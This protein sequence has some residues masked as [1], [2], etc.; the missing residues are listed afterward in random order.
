MRLGETR[1]EIVGLV[2]IS[3]LATVSF[4]WF[5]GQPFLIGNDT[6]LPLNLRTIDSYFY[7]LPTNLAYAKLDVSKFTFLLPLGLLLKLYSLSGLP[8]SAALYERAW[9]YVALAFCGVSVFVLLTALDKKMSLI[10]KLFA[11]AVFMFNFFHVWYWVDVSYLPIMEAFFPLVLALYV[12]GIQGGGTLWKAAATA[13]VWTITVTPGYGIPWVATNWLSILLFLVFY[14]TTVR[15]KR[16][17]KKALVFTFFMAIVWSASNAL[18][19]LPLFSSFGQELQRHTIPGVNPGY[20]FRVN[21]VKLID[22]LRFMGLYSFSGSYKGSPYF[23]WY[24]S[25]SSPLITLASFATPVLAFLAFLQGKK[26]GKRAITCFG[27]LTIVYLFLA[28]GP[29]EPFGSVNAFLFSR[30]G[31]DFIFRSTY[32]RFMGYVVLGMSVMIGFTID[33]VMKFK[34]RVR[35]LDGVKKLSVL[36]LLLVLVGVLAHPLWTGSIYDQSGVFPSRRVT[37]PDYYYEAAEWIDR[38]EGDFNVLP[39][40]FPTAFRIVFSWENGTNGYR[41]NYPFMFLS[42][43]RFI[44]ND[45]GNSTGS[46]LV[47]MIVQGAIKDSRILNLMNV[48][49]V[50]FHRDTNWE[51]I[52]GNPEWVSGTPEQIQDSLGAIRGLVLERS[53]GKID[54]YRNDLWKPM[55]AYLLPFTNRSITAEQ[56][57]CSYTKSDDAISA[58]GSILD[59][60]ESARTVELTRINPTL[61]VASARTA[62][63]F[64]LVL[65]DQY[66]EGWLLEV[67]GKKYEPSCVFG[68]ANG[69]AL[70]VQGDLKMTF[71]YQPQRLFYWGAFVSSISLIGSAGY[72]FYVGRTWLTNTRTT[73]RSKVRASFII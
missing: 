41:A 36:L 13:L 61:Y 53:F 68:F 38:Q 34:V 22:G 58:Y 9:I 17:A 15:S 7:A 30:F 37:I 60:I 19:I 2:I 48:R 29:N 26:R 67:N 11:S 8:F 71:N 28:K 44:I 63:S 16:L 47:S 18:W 54:V 40:P 46:I 10:A 51:Y 70:D 50:F 42:S 6:H 62:A 39:L 52:N 1:E 69:Y 23:P 33:H 66:D 14:V 25:Y 56:W 3:L 64:I 20:L 31:L 21:S 55:H 72:L 5:R 12:Y 4:T 57:T 73:Q 65:N 35:V 49:Y 45:F 43:K 27:I 32:S 24:E 59:A